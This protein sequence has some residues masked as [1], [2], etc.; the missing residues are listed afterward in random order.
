M[1]PGL[2]VEF[3]WSVDGQVW[4]AELS[5]SVE[6]LSG[7][8]G[9]ELRKMRCCALS[10]A[11]GTPDG[12]NSTHSTH[13]SILHAR[14]DW[15]KYRYRYRNTILVVVRLDLAIGIRRNGHLTRLLA[16]SLLICNK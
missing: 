15:L 8:S 1:R 7:G 2:F 4:S 5:W 16:H 12:L 9:G 14:N 6:Q 3:V 11:A 10:N 13:C